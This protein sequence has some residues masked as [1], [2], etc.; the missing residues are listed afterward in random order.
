MW[1]QVNLLF[2]LGAVCGAF[3]QAVSLEYFLAALPGS[4]GPYMVLFFCSAFF[5]VFFGAAT[6]VQL[7][8]HRLNKSDWDYAWTWRGGVRL[9]L[10]GLFD[11]L[12]GILVVY[13]SLPWHVPS[14]YQPL[15]LQASIPFN[16][17]FTLFI[18]RG[19]RYNFLQ[20]LGAAL[21][22]GAILISLIPDMQA[23]VQ[24][25]E[26]FVS[27][28][29]WIAILILSCVPGVLMNI[30]E[31]AI[32][33]DRRNMSIP[34]VLF[35][36]SA[37]QFTFMAAFWWTDI[38]PNFGFHGKSHNS[39]APPFHGHP[40]EWKQ[41]VALGFQCMFQPTS[42]AARKEGGHCH[43]ALAYGLAFCLTY[44]MS[45]VFG[46]LLFRHASA[47]FNAI[48]TSVG[49]PLATIYWYIF[50]VGAKYVGNPPLKGSR[51]YALGSLPLAFVG[52]VIFR[53][54]EKLPKHKEETRMSAAVNADD[55][56]VERL[57]LLHG[58]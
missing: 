7:A 22:I 55:G 41:G 35:L 14:P 3:G 26:L 27:G 2:P 20:L 10:I 1:W 19:R 29:W 23:K 47:N 31:E 28:Y 51:A 13:S 15:L 4:V 42:A 46:S 17:V 58:R 44:V 33:D 18:L 32:F 56:Q 5:T 8:T 37:W 34:L 38:L 12:N 54:F 48:V 57:P 9:M 30:V 36:E 53:H 24:H 52:A 49:N 11:S 40:R 43:V 45:Y 39:V 6:A 16:L 21:V 50:P 25:S